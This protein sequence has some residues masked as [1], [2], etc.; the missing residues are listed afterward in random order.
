[1]SSMRTLTLADCCEI[2]SGATP[3]TSVDEYWD[4]DIF[5]A[6]PKDLSD[7]RSHYISNTLRKISKAGLDSCAANVL[8]PNS[9]LFSSRAPIGHV[10]INTVPMATNQGFKSFIPKRDL[11]DTKF[12]F[13]WLRANRAYL[14]S[15]GNGATFKEVSKATVSRIEIPL[16]AVPEQRRI[17]AILD[18]TDALRAKRREALAQLNSLAKS[19]FIEMF[20]D[21][22]RSPKFPGN[23][24][25]PFVEAN[26]GKSAKS[27]FSTDK[28][29]IPIYGG[30]GINGYATSALYEYPVLV[31][32]R[33]GQQC[34]N[35]FITEGPSWVTDNAI[36]VRIA[37]A[38][39]LNAI[40]VLHAFHGSD[41]SNRVKH[42][43]LPFINQGMILDNPIPIPPLVLQQTF[44][45]RIQTVEA[46][47]ARHHAALKEL[48]SLFA[49]LQYR[50]FRGEL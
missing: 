14:E 34:G 25:R 45:T 5:W 40:Y 29:D 27:V 1:M 18:Q 10:A 4:G 30:N 8:P 36:V 26:S 17:A 21:V 20:G 16:P 22:I 32:G 13:H 3:S 15:L 9:V 2:V 12:L 35:A 11:I 43:D 46:L 6:T 28:T 49:S 42:L 41:F 7:L 50:A 24:I 48:D 33:V 23:G 37:D 47:N 39:K 38:T 19:I 44:A 31:F